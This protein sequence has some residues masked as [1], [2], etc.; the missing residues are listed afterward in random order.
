VT[1]ATEEAKRHFWRVEAERA[2]RRVAP[3]FSRSRVAELLRE[4]LSFAPAMVTAAVPRRG[5][6]AL[7]AAS[8]LPPPCRWVSGDEPTHNAVSF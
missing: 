6:M 5:I 3:S 4:H 1:F 7:C 2:E 8:H